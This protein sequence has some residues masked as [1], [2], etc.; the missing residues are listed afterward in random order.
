[1]PNSTSAGERN[2]E[3]GLRNDELSEHMG[4]EERGKEG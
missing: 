4:Q 3:E 1:M 2:F